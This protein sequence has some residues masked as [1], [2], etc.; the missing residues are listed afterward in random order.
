MPLTVKQ[1]DAIKPTGKRFE[2]IDAHGLSVRVSMTGKKTF[3]YRYSFNGKQSRHDY[4]N[5][6]TIT[7]AEAR[8]LHHDFKDKLA[9]GITPKTKEFGSIDKVDQ[10]FEQWHKKYNLVNR[11]RPEA[12]K[13]LIDSD[14]VPSIG[15]I[16]LKRL[17]KSHFRDMLDAIIARGSHTHAERVR[18]LCKQVLKWGS[19][20]DYIEHNPIQNFS[21]S[22]IGY[23]Y[24]PKDR[25]LN[26]QEIGAVWNLLDL[27]NMAPSTINALRVMMLTGLRRSEPYLAEWKHISFATKTWVIPSANNKSERENE[28][29]MSSLLIEVL[30]NQQA[31]VNELGGSK[32]VF[33]SANNLDRHLNP[34][35]VTRAVKRHCDN[36][37]WRLDQDTF[38]PDWT[39]HAL[40]HTFETKLSEI[41]VDYIV[42]KRL[43]NHA[44][45]NMSDVYNHAQLNDKKLEAMQK[46][47]D[48]IMRCANEQLS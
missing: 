13:L 17:T 46:W 1:I 42:L 9:R 2:V 4:G 38:I 20:R 45:G 21:A 19:E 3:Q 28:V 25:F 41:G 37:F 40:R 47:A 39:P 23:K 43:I 5:Y 33:P 44:I 7:L 15:H 34:Q 10:L 31:F 48:K 22:A 12:A 36:N 18:A 35:S 24:K 29:M 8:K 6:P 26:D 32:W 16:K 30:K 11:K 27:S 14:I